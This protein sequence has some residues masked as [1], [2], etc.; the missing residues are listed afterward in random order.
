MRPRQYFGKASAIVVGSIVWTY[1]KSIRNTQCGVITMHRSSRSTYS[2][3]PLM[4]K[5][6]SFSHP[7]DE[8][9]VQL[10]RGDD[11]KLPLA[12]P[13]FF[14]AHLYPTLFHWKS[15]LCKRGI[16]QTDW[17]CT[18]CTNT[19]KPSE[20]PPDESPSLQQDAILSPATIPC[21][22]C[23]SQS[24]QGISFLTPCS[25]VVC[26]CVFALVLEVFQRRSGVT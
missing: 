24:A 26:Q 5:L 12:V 8:T 11:H 23:P 7:Y 21:I 9:Q 13:E 17:P 3:Y 6:I 19:L 4:R 2:T 16:D 18:G 10:R 1:L 20:P 15:Q 25:N 22:P 14:P